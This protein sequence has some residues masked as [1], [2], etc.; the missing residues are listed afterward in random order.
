MNLSCTHRP[1][2]HGSGQASRAAQALQDGPQVEAP[3]EQVLHEGE[4]A[5]R[6]LFEV[7]GVEGPGQGSLKEGLQNALRSEH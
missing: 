3:V 1:H 5:V 4:L 6:V 7:E 2:V